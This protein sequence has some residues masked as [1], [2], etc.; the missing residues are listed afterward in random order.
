MKTRLGFLLVAALAGC[1]PS[2]AKPPTAERSHATE[3]DCNDV[4]KRIIG[5]NGYVR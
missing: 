2:T 3:D 1:H 5:S 4:Y